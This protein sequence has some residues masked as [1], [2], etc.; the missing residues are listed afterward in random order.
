[1]DKVIPCTLE[2][3][4]HRPL[5]D[6]FIQALEIFPSRQIEFARLNVS[7]M[8]TSKRRLLRLVQEGHVKGWDDPRRIT[9]AL[10]QINGL[11]S[12]ALTLLS[13]LPPRR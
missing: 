9:S 11:T 12:E 3:E 7:Y 1:M 4:N 10:I 8:I 5:Y 13:M 6:W 2:F